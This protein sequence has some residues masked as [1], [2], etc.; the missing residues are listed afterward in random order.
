V[1]QFEQVAL[2]RTTDGAEEENAEAE[3]DLAMRVL[4]V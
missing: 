4:I 2:Q 3:G 1:R